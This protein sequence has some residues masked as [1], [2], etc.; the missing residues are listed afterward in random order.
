[1]VHEDIF[2]EDMSELTSGGIDEIVKV[3]RVPFSVRN[4]IQR[5]I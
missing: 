3:T 1:M 4:Q 5:T 2:P